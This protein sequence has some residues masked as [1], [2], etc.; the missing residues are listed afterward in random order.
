MRARLSFLIVSERRSLPGGDPEGLDLAF[1]GDGDD[2]GVGL[3]HG[4]GEFLP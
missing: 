3:H 4:L 2:D 1:G